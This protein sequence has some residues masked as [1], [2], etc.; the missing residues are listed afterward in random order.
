M[1]EKQRTPSIK[2]EGVLKHSPEMIYFSEITRKGKGAP[3][4]SVPCGIFPGAAYELD[5]GV[6]GST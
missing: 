5:V 1:N 2:I 3:A 6:V 4:A